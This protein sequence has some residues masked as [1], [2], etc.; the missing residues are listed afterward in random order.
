MKRGLSII[1]V[2][3]S[4]C[5][6]VAPALAAPVLDFGTGA[7]GAGGIITVTGSDITGVG[8]GLDT[9]IVTG[10]NY[11]NIYNLS[12]DFTTGSDGSSA[13]L[14]FDTVTG[15]ITITGFVN[16]VGTQSNVTLMS[17]KIE[18]ISFQ[19][20]ANGN[21]L[22]ISEMTGTDT[23]DP[24]LLQALGISATSFAFYGFN[25][26]AKNEAGQYVATSTDIVNTPVPIPSAILL[27]GGG[28]A[29]LAVF[30][31]RLRV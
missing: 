29:G 15:D 30:R 31:R 27:M 17:G 2:I 8:I 3:F 24:A 11:D 26:S 14:N 21:I 25:F 28:L 12:G 9:L 16:G 6:F 19:F 7:A 5:V 4:L 1:G 10:T 23:K 20:N 22:G 18:N 13:L